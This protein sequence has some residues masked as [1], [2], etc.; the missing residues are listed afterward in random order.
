MYINKVKKSSFAMMS[1]A[2][3]EDKVKNYLEA[4]NSGKEQIVYKFNKEKDSFI[5]YCFPKALNGDGFYSYLEV[6]SN[7]DIDYQ[8]ESINKA[9]ALYLFLSEK[10][11]NKTLE[12]LKSLYK[13]IDESILKYANLSKEENKRRLD[14]RKNF[15]Y[16]IEEEDN[17]PNE[18]FKVESL[19]LS[20]YIDTS[21]LDKYI[22][23]SIILTSIEGKETVIS[24]YFFLCSL[25]E[26]IIKGNKK[27]T[28]DYSK[29]ANKTQPYVIISSLSSSYYANNKG[30]TG[31][32]LANVLPLLLGEEIK[33]NGKTYYI[34][35]NIEQ[36]RIEINENGKPKVIPDLSKKTIFVQSAKI[37]STLEKSKRIINA[38]NFKTEKAKKI[39]SFLGF[40]G[41]K[42]KDF[43]YVSDLVIDKMKKE[44]SLKINGENSKYQI[45]LY[46]EYIKALDTLSFK[47][48]FEYDGEE[49]E[50]DTF[51]GSEFSKAY[52]DS[53]IEELTKR[54]G[55]ENGYLKENEYVY[56]F[57]TSSYKEL[58]AY[59]KLFLSENLLNLVN[60]T[61]KVKTKLLLK[62]GWINASMSSSEFSDEEL[63]AILEAYKQKRKF[64]LISNK[65]VDLD[66]EEVK[67]FAKV[68]DSLNIDKFHHQSSNLPFWTTFMLQSEEGVDVD[69]DSSLS[70]FINDIS[71]FKN[72]EIDLPISI[73]DKLRPYQL[74]GIKWLASLN[75]YH[76]PGLLADDM[77]L[78]KTLQTISFISTLKE[79]GPILIVCPK[80]VTYNWKKEIDKWAPFL[81][82][83]VISGNIETRIRLLSS[84]KENKTIV[85]ITS[86]D[87][88]RNDIEKYTQIP[89]L[90]TVLDEAQTIK[91]TNAK[92]TLA[93]K[94]LKSTYKLALTGTP[95]ENSAID[96]FSIFDFLMEGYL[97]D[98]NEFARTYG[99]APS[100]ERAKKLYNKIKPFYL[101]RKK[102]DVLKDLP[103]KTIENISIT[104][105]EEEAK[106]YE[107]Y[108]ER[109]RREMNSGNI[110]SILASLVRLRTI[111]CDAPAFFDNANFEPS[112]FQYILEIL[113]Q[114]IENGHKFVI[115]SS[116]VKALHHL[117]SYLEE[118][119]INSSIIEG[120]TS[121]EDRIALSESFNND[122]EIKVML[123]SLKAGGTGLNLY[124]ADYVIHLD[125]WWNN[126][127]EEQATDRA[128]RIG[129]TRPV[130]V[131]KL[132][133]FNTIEEKVLKLQEIKKE[134]AT[135]L[136]KE[137]DEAIAKLSKEDIK[138]LLS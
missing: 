21:H 18:Y 70:S 26:A 118:H 37:I 54:H 58:G 29:V 87:S 30:V 134:I 92:K 133:S 47:T 38:Y 73:K 121:G 96:L 122:D 135:S 136:I 32:E 44:K 20:V 59:C 66:S 128:H 4:L 33:V 127:A 71:N 114:G 23:L 76:L 50:K 46:I 125:P 115:F 13:T 57:L 25:A 83:V 1:F 80:S 99:Y 90:L 102:E 12:E 95:V 56:A 41:I 88:L 94:S 10:E 112:K 129:Q 89:F 63:F 62:E 117:S 106:I 110:A 14:L 15:L 9:Y 5:Y 49:I 79:K 28:I 16:E 64:I 7:G 39:I 34:N 78:G 31:E 27:I 137:G 126:A 69:L 53:F 22:N 45:N 24:P 97:G 75:K 74:D 2:F 107:A 104:M 130:T 108:L 60:K 82:S 85:A 61:P 35:E 98:R 65:I 120:Q 19:T 124:G 77:G 101:R 67:N 72:L 138:Y 111:C 11:K 48:K 132:I 36:G 43:E 84:L 100:K 17:L 131:L 55:I 116:F 123:V 3:K 52:Y 93:V 40:K 103:P 51:L 68:A 6:N 86:Y 109:A 105:E 81:P 8:S 119:G 113:N 91:N 42:E